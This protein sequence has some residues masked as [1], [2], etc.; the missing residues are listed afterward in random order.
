VTPDEAKQ[1]RQLLTKNVASFFASAHKYPYL[2]QSYYCNEKTYGSHCFGLL[3]SLTNNF[4][5]VF[6]N[7][8]KNDNDI[9][10]KA[11]AF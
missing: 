6:I 11:F 4:V 8:C 1:W 5:E 10:S 2:D 7:Q 9:T 3:A